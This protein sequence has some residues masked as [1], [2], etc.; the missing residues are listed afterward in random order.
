MSFSSFLTFIDKS[1]Q[2]KRKKYKND[3]RRNHTDGWVQ[4]SRKKDAKIAAAALNNQPIGG[5][6]RYRFRDDLWNIKYLKGFKWTQ[7]TDKI[8][9]E[10]AERDKRMRTELTQAK[11]EHRFYVEKI[12]Q[13]KVISKIEK[14]RRKEGDGEEDARLI[15]NFKQRK[16]MSTPLNG[17]DE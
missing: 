15:R 9:H 17:A 16:V 7:L 3:N 14:R 2:K 4:F 6:K 13:S 1:I 11:R 5:K 12:E 8:A 10:K